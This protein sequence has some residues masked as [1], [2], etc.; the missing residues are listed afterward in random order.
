MTLYAQKRTSG[1]TSLLFIYAIIVAA[2]FVLIIKVFVSEKATLWEIITNRY[3]TSRGNQWKDDLKHDMKEIETE[4]G[5]G[6][7]EDFK[8]SEG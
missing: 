7:T 4:F 8:R 1:G 3:K 6:V 2:I 5:S